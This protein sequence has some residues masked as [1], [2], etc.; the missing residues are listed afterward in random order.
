MSRLTSNLSSVS[1]VMNSD[2]LA[3]KTPSTSDISHGIA[4]AS[5]GAHRAQ[6]WPGAAHGHEDTAAVETWDPDPR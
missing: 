2:T 4:G 1:Y 6:R 3:A 5:C